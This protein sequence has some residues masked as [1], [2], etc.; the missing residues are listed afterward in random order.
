M[1][2]RNRLTYEL[3]KKN[4]MAQLMIGLDWIEMQSQ[5]TWKKT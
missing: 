2:H 4:V 3:H 1:T 5:A